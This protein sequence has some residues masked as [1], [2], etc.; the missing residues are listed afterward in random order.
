MTAKDF[1]RILSQVRGMKWF[2]EFAKI[3][4]KRPVSTTFINGERHSFRYSPLS[5]VA[6]AVRRDFVDVSKP[7]INKMLNLNP[8]TFRRIKKA[9]YQ[10]TGYSKAVRLKL[11]K[12][13][14]LLEG[15]A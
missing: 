4:W 8:R 7:D 1:Y 14:R 2:V 13:C 6:S 3:D 9:T 12:A 15:L 11:L 10:D 5:A